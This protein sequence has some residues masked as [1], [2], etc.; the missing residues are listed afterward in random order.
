MKISRLTF[1]AAMLCGIAGAANATRNP[2]PPPSG[3]VVHLFG[4]H[5][6]MSNVMPDLP[7][8]AASPAAA[9]PGNAA[10]APKQNAGGQIAAASQPAATDDPSLHDVLHQMFVVGDPNHPI[11]PSQGRVAERPAGN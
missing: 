1:A 3:V 7:G 2:T 10:A 11:Q 9:Q 4:P 8:A 6:V 5:S